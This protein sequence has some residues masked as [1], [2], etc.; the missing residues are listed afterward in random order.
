M[1]A[2]H[3][4]IRLC[5]PIA[6]VSSLAGCAV[7][8]RTPGAESSPLSDLAIVEFKDD[9]DSG[10]IVEVDDAPRP[11]W[12]VKR[13]EL[14]AGNHSFRINLNA[15]LASVAMKVSFAVESGHQYRVLPVVAIADQ[16]S[17]LAKIIIVDQSTGL[18]IP[19]QT[20]MLG[21]L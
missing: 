12:D 6:I 7:A 5:L 16:K 11:N 10:V 20:Q 13:Y 9:R 17:A 3:T 4:L 8:Y 19:R 2:T 21:F 1:I 18:E 15:G 14:S